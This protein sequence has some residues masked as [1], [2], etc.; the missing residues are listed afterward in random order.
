MGFDSAM[1]DYSEAVIKDE[2]SVNSCFA[3]LISQEQINLAKKSMEIEKGMVLEEIER[4]ERKLR[5]LR[6]RIEQYEKAEKA[7]EALTDIAD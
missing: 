4:I 5:P 2:N 1:R 7:I 3:R 6:A